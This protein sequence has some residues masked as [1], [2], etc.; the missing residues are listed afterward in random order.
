MLT[1]VAASFIKHVGATSKAV[2]WVLVSAALAAGTFSRN[3]DYSSGVRLART[4]IE[5]HPTSVGHLMLATQLLEAGGDREE[6]MGQLRQALPGAPRAHYALGVE[7][8]KDGKLNEAIDELQ[9]FVREQPLL[10]EAVSARQLLGRAFAKQ[11]RWPE[12]VEQHRM[13]LRMNPSSVQRIETE[14]LLAEADL[15]AQSF[16]EAAVH[17]TGST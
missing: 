14:G 5:R 9:A 6:A 17:S 11:Q 2:A 10:L 4:V 13:V 12:A 7:L 3:R 1:V 16:A 8:F 15:G